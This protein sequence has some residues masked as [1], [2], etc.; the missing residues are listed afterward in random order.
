MNFISFLN[1]QNLEKYMHNNLFF[2]KTTLAFCICILFKSSNSICY[3]GVFFST[4]KLLLYKFSNDYSYFMWKKTRMLKNHIAWIILRLI[5]ESR[6]FFWRCCFL[7]RNKLL[8][9]EIEKKTTKKKRN[10]SSYIKQ[11]LW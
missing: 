2:F 4:H 11:V 8:R 5:K 7:W 1:C 10:L 6:R 9:K 3:A